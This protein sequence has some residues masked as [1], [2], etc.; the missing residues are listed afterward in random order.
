MSTSEDSQRIDQFLRTTLNQP[1]QE[2]A[3]RTRAIVADHQTAIDAETKRLQDWRNPDDAL[4]GMYQAR[5]TA[6]LK[7]NR[8]LR[9]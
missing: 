6:P 9:S 5:R 3:K 4:R 7:V 2:Q 8:P 1:R